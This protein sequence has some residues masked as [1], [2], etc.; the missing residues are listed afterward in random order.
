MWAD[1]E[2]LQKEVAEVEKELNLQSPAGV[3]GEQ[4]YAVVK[5]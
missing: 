4:S 1:P 2:L 3:S 5:W